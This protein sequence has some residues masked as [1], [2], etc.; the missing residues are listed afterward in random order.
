MQMTFVLAYLGAAQYEI[1]GEHYEVRALAEAHCRSIYRAGIVESAVLPLVGTVR[2]LSRFTEWPPADVLAQF[3]G[4]VGARWNIA[5]N[6]IETDG[7][8]DVLPGVGG[9]V[10]I[11]RARADQLKALGIEAAADR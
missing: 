7:P 4:Y 9:I 1:A 8:P 10:L 6:R 2:S 3:P 11:A 5:E